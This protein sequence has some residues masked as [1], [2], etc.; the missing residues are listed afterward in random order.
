MRV[1][2]YAEDMT[3]RLSITS[4][5]FDGH[6]YTGLRFWL[7]LP[8]TV[9]GKQYQ[10]PF[11]HKPGDDDS[12]AV[13][14]WGKRDL[15]EVLKKALDMLDEH[16]EKRDGPSTAANPFEDCC[17]QGCAVCKVKEDAP[18]D[19]APGPRKHAL[20]ETKDANRPLVICDSN[21]EVVLDLCKVCGKAEIELVDTPECPG[22]HA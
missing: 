19:L 11:M 12:S 13:T 7:E 1:N 21:G 10:G 4:K 9:S 15:R 22:A 14:F 18:S 8:A 3:D 17:G 20:W 6:V 16:Y 2:I 5:E